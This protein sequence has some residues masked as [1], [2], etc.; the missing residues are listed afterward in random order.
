VYSDES[1]HP[2]ESG[3]PIYIFV[4]SGIAVLIIPALVIIYRKRRRKA[5]TD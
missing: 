2:D 1:T 4:F 3:L 5:S